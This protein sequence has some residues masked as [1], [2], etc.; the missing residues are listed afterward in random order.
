MTIQ[1]T[2]SPLIA[3]VM[4]SGSLWLLSGWIRWIAGRRSGGGGG[5]ASGLPPERGGWLIAC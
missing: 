1:E 5:A 3:G 2:V 4:A